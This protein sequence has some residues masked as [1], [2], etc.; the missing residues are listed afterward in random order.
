MT[1]EGSAI[2]VE[3]R[4]K[5]TVLDISGLASVIDESR[6]T[7]MSMSVVDCDKVALEKAD[8]RRNGFMVI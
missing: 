4:S 3:P 2:V 6:D 1:S 8:E 7:S 5:S